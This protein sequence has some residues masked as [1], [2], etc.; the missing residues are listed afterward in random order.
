[1]CSGLFACLLGLRL[2]GLG[3]GV[4][5]GFLFGG[6]R[7]I[8]FLSGAHIT[9]LGLGAVVVHVPAAAFELYRWRMEDLLHCAAALGAFLYMA[10]GEFLYLLKLMLT[11]LAQILVKRHVKTFA[12]Q[13]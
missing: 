4:S 2:L 5:V 7:T 11:L 3:F 13:L 6:S 1:M 10:I 8:F 12:Y 9:W